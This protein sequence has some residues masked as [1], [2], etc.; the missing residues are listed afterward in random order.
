MNK[1]TESPSGVNTLL[2]SADESFYIS[3]NPDTGA[4]FGGNLFRADAGDGSETALCKDGDYQV[5]NGDF[6]KEYE[7]LISK[8]Y[9]TCLKFFKSQEE[10]QSSWS[11]DS[12]ILPP[13]FRE[14][15]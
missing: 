8:G 3:Y 11:T 12:K 10:A 4:T 9:A 13:V 6:R 5:L 15:V 14:F 1:W 2:Y 7:K